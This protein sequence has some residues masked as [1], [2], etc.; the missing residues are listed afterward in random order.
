M[1][2]RRRLRIYQ[3]AHWRVY[4]V[5]TLQVDGEIQPPVH[6]DTRV[7]FNLVCAPP[8]DGGIQ[9]SESCANE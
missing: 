9:A 1:K 6:A 4:L 3:L 7:S 2:L 8:V 5:C